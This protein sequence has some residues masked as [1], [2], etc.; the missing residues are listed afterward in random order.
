MTL[1]TRRNF[2][3]WLL[4]LAGLLSFP[5]IARETKADPRI[6]PWRSP[7]D[8]IGE[9]FLGEELEYDIG[10]WMFKQAAIARASFQRLEGKDQFLGTIQGETRGIL[11][12]VAR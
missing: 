8:P 4:G 12:W 10:F 5:L 9:F 1:L 7:G 2:F 11:G 6:S 3:R